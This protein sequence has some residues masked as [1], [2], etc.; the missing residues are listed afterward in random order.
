MCCVTV[1]LCRL[2]LLKL[3]RWC[4]RQAGVD[5]YDELSSLEVKRVF[6]LELEVG[7]TIDPGQVVA[8]QHLIEVRTDRIVS[9]R[10]IA[11][12]KD[13]NGCHALQGRVT[14]HS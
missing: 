7:E 1:V 11:P 12:G 8:A 5:K 6:D 13:Q 4:R 2:Q 14:L 9:P 3:E 10:R